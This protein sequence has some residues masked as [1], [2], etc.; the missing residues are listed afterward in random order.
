MKFDNFSAID[1]GII[2]TPQMTS[3]QPVKRYAPRVIR[4]MR[5]R[6]RTNF[7]FGVAGGEGYITY[8]LISGQVIPNATIND[9]GASFIDVKQNDFDLGI[10]DINL[11]DFDIVSVQDTSMQDPT[12]SVKSISGYD[13]KNGAIV[14]IRLNKDVQVAVPTTAE[15][16]MEQSQEAMAT[17]TSTMDSTRS[18]TATT[19]TQTPLK[20]IGLLAVGFFG[21]ILA[22]KFLYKK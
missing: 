22:Y 10:R 14:T 2:P 7:F 11:G 9:I 8:S 15:T 13:L 21:G 1:S 16:A 6:K 12:S 18:T 4:K 19:A 5:N 17:T 3:P 20:T